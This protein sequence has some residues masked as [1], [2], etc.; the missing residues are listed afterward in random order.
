MIS[1]TKK[2]HLNSPTNGQGSTM[3]TL[4]DHKMI[5][6]QLYVKYS[7]SEQPIPVINGVHLH[8]IYNPEREATGFVSSQLENLKTA[9]NILIFGLG[10]GYHISHIEEKMK[11][12]HPAGYNI[13]V[14]EP[15]TEIVQKWRELAPTQFSE[16]VKVVSY[17]SIKEFYQDRE[18]VEFMSTR[19]AVVPHP[20]SFQLS[21]TFFKDF[22][23]Y[24][25]PKKID[26]SAFFVESETFRNYLT[27]ENKNETT[28][29]FF[30]RV[31]GKSFLQS[32][33]FLSLALAELVQER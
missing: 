27:S 7:K 17:N 14:I 9:K 16:H 29:E 2:P 10:F 24:C 19:P 6:D 26:D 1:E 11:S 15:N 8:S 22:M 12:F 25:Y 31:R 28:D 23:S 3:D 33:D 20:A 30:E 5:R 4:R 32:Y 18:L 21:M 13:F